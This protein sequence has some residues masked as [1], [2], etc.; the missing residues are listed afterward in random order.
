MAWADSI[1]AQLDNVPFQQHRDIL[2]LLL[3][4]VVNDRHNNICITL[5]ISTQD[6]MSSA[7]SEPEFAAQ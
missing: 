2:K 3:D 1:G 6:F 4:Q 5:G 7:N